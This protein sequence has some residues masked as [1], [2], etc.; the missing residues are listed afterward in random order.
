VQL[1]DARLVDDVSRALA[2]FPADSG[3]DIEVTESG[4]MANIVDAI[5]TLRQIREL[6]VGIALD[7]F[8]TG[9]SSLSYIFQ[10]PLTT[11]KIDRSFINGMTSEPDKLTI[12]STVISLGRELRLQVVA[13]GVETEEQAKLLGL[14]RCDQIQG[15][16]IGRP[17]PAEDL[18]RLLKPC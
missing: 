16:L 10:L 14:L 11:L 18:A 8:G 17:M 9:H 15:F 4:V 1:A 6:G 7:D 2:E 5:E 3:L 13:E 12:V